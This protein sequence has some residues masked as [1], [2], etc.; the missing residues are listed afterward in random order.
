MADSGQSFS[1]SDLAREFD[2]TTRTIRY[3]EDEGLLTPTRR[4]RNRIFSGRDRT[5][6]KL[7]LRGKRLGFSL[8]EIADILGL[9]DDAPGESGQLRYFLD[10][11]ADRRRHLEHQ[12]RDIEVT[13]AELASLEARCRLR[14][15]ELDRDEGAPP[16]RSRAV[17]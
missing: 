16:P 5:R 4:G 11:I 9:Y 3:Y 6:L 17:C 14:L 7:I 12:R 13:L 2:V 15:D 1:I 10:R 8:S